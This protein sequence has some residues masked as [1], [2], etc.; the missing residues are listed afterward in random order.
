[1]ALYSLYCAEVP[2]RNCSLT[3]SLTLLDCSYHGL[4]VPSLDFSYPGLFVPWTVRTVDYSYPLGLFVPW[5]VRTVDCSYRGLFVPSW[6][7]RTMDCSY[8]PWTFRTLDC[9]YRGLFVPSLDCSDHGLF[10]PFLDDSYH[11]EK[12]NIV[13]AVWVKKNPW[14]FLTFFSKPLGIFRPNITCLLCVHTYGRLQIFIQ[15][16]PILTNLY[17]IKCDHP[18]CVSADGGHLEHMMVIA[19]NMAQLCHSCR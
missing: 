19:L 11:V 8:R 6:T 7:V 12:G 10:V 3:H 17:H 13:Y 4:F 18:A 9:S 15:L 2:L 1:M 14:G 16:S 5:T